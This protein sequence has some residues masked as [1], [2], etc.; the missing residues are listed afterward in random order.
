MLFRSPNNPNGG[1]GYTPPE[2]PPTV[3]EEV[4]DINGIWLT[5]QPPLVYQIDQNGRSYIWRVVGA[6]DSGTGRIE[7]EN[8][9]SQIGGRDVVYFI[10]AKFPDGRPSELRTHDAQFAGIVLMREQ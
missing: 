4:I 3:I 5:N 7:G 8:V 2:P 1:N 6:P 10:N 9:I